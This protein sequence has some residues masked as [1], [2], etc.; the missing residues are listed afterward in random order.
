MRVTLLGFTVPD[1]T[2]R[3]I[4]TEDPVMPT[5]TQRFAWALVDALGLNGAEVD[6]ISV[7]PVSN[8]PASPRLVVRGRRFEERGVPGL[9]LPFINAL[10]LKHLTRF[11]ACLLWGT[12]RIRRNRSEWLLVH[13]VHSPFLWFAIF[14]RA[15]TGVQIAAVLSDPPGVV[16]RSDGRAARLLKRL[17]IEVTKLALARF[18]GVIVLSQPLADD[19]APGV[20]HLV[21]EGLVALASH[22]LR[23]GVERA[24][25]PTIVYAGG[26]VEEYGV[27]SLVRAIMESDLDVRL[28]LYG[29]GDAV[30]EIVEMSVQDRRI[31]PPVLV[32]PNELPEHYRR[33][34]ALV[35]PRQPDQ[36]FVRYSFPSKLIEYMSTGVPVVSTRLPSIPAEYDDHIVWAESGSPAGLRQAIVRCL[37]LSPD[38]AQR[39][40]DGASEFIRLTR[41]PRAQ[42][43]RV[44]DFLTDCGVKAG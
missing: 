41:S 4:L 31:A 12:R 18:D 43:R 14:A 33:A 29:A 8:Y 44:V 38:E 17:D 37:A 32:E 21:M 19:F 16:R 36:D 6:L 15:R 40:G 25:S 24:G 13:G 11:A 34:R 1:E 22:D 20:P 28:E 5:Q 30:Q 7:A 27:L 2:F 26:L 3:K 39:L 35:Q 10:V 23:E 42:G 9:L